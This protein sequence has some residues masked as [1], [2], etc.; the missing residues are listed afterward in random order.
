MGHM[1]F[2][3]GYMAGLFLI[4]L[5]ALLVLVGKTGAT[6]ISEKA[7]IIVVRIH[8]GCYFADLMAGNLLH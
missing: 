2:A 1:N 6:V 8:G 3:W 4:H 5:T 7:D